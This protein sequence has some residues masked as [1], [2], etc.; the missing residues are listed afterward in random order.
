MMDPLGSFFGS[1]RETS[2][3]SPHCTT[4]SGI[5]CSKCADAR[6]VSYSLSAPA[7]WAGVQHTC[8]VLLYSLEGLSIVEAA[9]QLP[10][11][12]ARQ[13]KSQWNSPRRAKQWQKQS[14][15]MPPLNTMQSVAAPLPE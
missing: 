11:Y 1:C 13:C 3:E 14:K 2:C 4:Y 8:T 10:G 9:E 5:E 6:A 15:C 7:T 12:T